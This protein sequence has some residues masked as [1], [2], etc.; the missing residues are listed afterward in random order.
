MGVYK[1]VSS[2]NNRGSSSS[3]FIAVAIST[4]VALV[5]K[6]IQLPLSLFYFWPDWIAL[7]VAFWALHQ[8]GR[9]G[10]VAGFIIGTLL[11]VLFVRTFGVLGL[12]LATLAFVINSTHQQLRALSVWQQIF[13]IGLYVGVFKLLTGWLSGM[14]SDFVITSEYW[15]SLLGDILIWPFATILLHELRRILR[16][17]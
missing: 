12:G 4:F 3:L 5:L 9:F 1:V 15:Y 2:T 17:R 8:P 13:V 7:V 14:V 16:L 6:L 10:P 11:E